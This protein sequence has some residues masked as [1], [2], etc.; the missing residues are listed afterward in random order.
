MLTLECLTEEN[1]KVDKSCYS[2]LC[3]PDDCSPICDPSLCA[4]HFGEDCWPDV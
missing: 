4:P 1:A 2:E 3:D